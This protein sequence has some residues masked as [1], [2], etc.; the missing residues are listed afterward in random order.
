MKRKKII[1]TN[2]KSPS[3][4]PTGKLAIRPADKKLV[5]L[6]RSI[7]NGVIEKIKVRNGLPISFKFAW[8]TKKATVP[9]KRT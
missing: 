9:S 6:M 1:Y 3:K 8:K 5:Q 2:R 7:G 4:N